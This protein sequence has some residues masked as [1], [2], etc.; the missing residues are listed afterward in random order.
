M[1]SPGARIKDF[2]MTSLSQKFCRVLLYR[3]LGWKEEISIELPDRCVM[4]IAPH[5]SNCDFLIGELYNGAENLRAGF[6]MKKEWFFWP[7]GLLLKRMGGIPV[8]RDKKTSLTERLAQMALERQRFRLAI[9]PEGTRS[10]VH[11]WKKGFYY[12]A[13]KAKIP[14]VLF[15]IDYA[16]KVIS[17]T[18]MIYPTGEE[19]KELREIKAFYSSSQGRHPERFGI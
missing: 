9:T 10:L 19:E 7:I 2:G 6:L 8:W 11:D 5:T 13:L 14:I 15:S 3:C 4:A 18:K 16:K 17:C 12:I 1:R